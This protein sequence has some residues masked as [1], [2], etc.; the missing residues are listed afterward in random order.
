MIVHPLIYSL[1][2]DLSLNTE[3]TFDSITE[4]NFFNLLIF[5]QIYWYEW[6]PHTPLRPI[7]E[8]TFKSIT[9]RVEVPWVICYGW[10]GS[11]T[12]VRWSKRW[13]KIDRDLDQILRSPTKKSW[14]SV[15]RIIIDHRNLSFGYFRSKSL[16]F[17]QRSTKA[18]RKVTE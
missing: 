4:Y 9:R 6:L 13:V 5:F 7:T 15:V 17:V 14:T 12:E 11:C 16:S 18:R 2:M 3:V 10:W 1:T 8:E